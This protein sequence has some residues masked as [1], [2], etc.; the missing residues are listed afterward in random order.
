M[1]L[2]YRSS[3]SQRFVDN[4]VTLACRIPQTLEKLFFCFS[5]KIFRM[6]ESVSSCLQRTN[7]FLERFFE[8]LTDA[9]Y[10]AYRTH[11]CSKLVFHTFEFLKCPA[12]ELD[13][14]IISVRNV[15]IQCTVLSARNIFQRHA[16]RKHCGYK[17]DRESCRFRCKRRRT[18][19]SRV[20]LDNDISVCLRIMR[21]LYVTAADHLNRIYYFMR[22]FL[23]TLLNFF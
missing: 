1:D 11:L 19:R 22:F 10:F 2:F 20:D 17:R 9:H 4:K 15:F 5:V 23:Q 3:F 13:H 21:P 14:N 6:T 18:R 16:C 8:V 12:R 7:R